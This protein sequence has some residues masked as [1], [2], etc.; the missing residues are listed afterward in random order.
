M[1]YM[2]IMMLS[3]QNFALN[4]VVRVLQGM[5]GN[6]PTQYITGPK[7]IAVPGQLAG[8]YK[9]HQMHGKLP[10]AQLVKPAKDLSGRGGRVSK[11]L[12]RKL[13]H[14]K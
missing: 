4:N 8:L 5:F 1:V 14:R 9:A 7:S 10:W 13:V 6:N 3:Y 12:H 11:S 2:F